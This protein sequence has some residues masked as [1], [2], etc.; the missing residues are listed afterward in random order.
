[1]FPFHRLTLKAQEALQKAQDK[2]IDSHHSEVKAIHIL[3]G[4]LQVEETIVQDMLQEMK[5]DTKMLNQIVEQELIR[6]PKIFSTTNVANLYLAQETVG[7]LDQ[8]HYLARKMNDEFISCEH[9]FL[10]L[11]EVKSVAKYVLER[12]GITPDKVYRLLQVLRKGMKVSDE[13]PENKLKVLERYT[14][15][16]TA[17]AK[18]RK[19]DPIIGRD[20]EIR[21]VIEILSR[22]TKNNPVIIGEPGVGKTA[23]VEGLAQRI[24]AGEVPDSLKDKEILSLDIGVLIA[25]SKYRGEFEERLKSLIREIQANPG[26][27]ILFVDEMHTLVG[28]GAAEGAVDASNLLKPSLTKGDFRVIGATTFRDYKIY[29]EKDPAFARRFQP[30]YI[31]EPS[32]DETIAILRGLKEKYELHH[33]VKIS[34]QAIV[35]AAKLSARYITSRYLPDKAIDLLDESAAS[36]KLKLESLPED[37]AEKRSLLKQLEIEREVLLKEE[38]TDKSKLHKLEAKIKKLKEEEEKLVQKWTKEKKVKERYQQLKQTLDQLRWEKDEAERNGDYTHVAEILYGEMPKI[39]KELAELEKIMK[40]NKTILKDIVTEEDIAE[41]VARWTGIPVKKIVEDEAEKLLR[42]EEELRKRIVGQ[43]EAVNAVANA[44]RRARAGLT[45]PNRPI[46]SFLFLGPTG[47]GKT[48]LARTLAE[49]MFNDEKAMVRFDMSEFME[50]H[51]VAKLIGSPP[52]YVGYEEGGQLT[53][54]IKHRPYSL[55]L[56]DEIEK[57]HPEVLNILLQILDDGRLTDSKGSTVDFKNTII[58][59]TSNVGS[60]LFRKIGSIGFVSDLDGENT[61][62]KNKLNSVLRDYFKPEFLNRIDEIIIFKPLSLEDIKKIV[63]IQLS[64]VK[65][66]LSEKGVLVEFSDELK[67][68]LVQKG[69][70]EI[71]GARPLKRAIQKYVLDPLSEYLIAGKIKENQKLSL[72]FVNGQLAVNAKHNK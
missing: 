51:S 49:F 61:D 30:V 4:L 59:M 33:G 35:A 40:K 50:P 43:D 47:V 24:V 56:F 68:V 71:Y 10:A 44:L 5:V 39:E 11:T 34:D 31:S 70:D 67:E 63:D 3:W 20:K 37:I 41:I 23:I 12:F 19:L 48:E 66:Q 54:T 2:A 15:N 16:L 53:E 65:K 8:A 9:I 14:I 18:Q 64:R 46:A 36:L 52:G 62:L 7:I 17:L 6:I 25:G 26:K 42:A 29:I 58:I 1:M 57:A 28:A 27:Y 55:I 13:M 21:R 22:R 38:N 45:D 32:I 72:T 69:F 60:H